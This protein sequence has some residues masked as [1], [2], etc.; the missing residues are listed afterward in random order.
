MLGAWQAMSGQPSPSSH[1]GLTSM[2]RKQPKLGPPRPPFLA[3]PSSHPLTPML[4][5]F[6][7]QAL[8]IDRSVDRQSLL[9]CSHVHL[10]QG[11]WVEDVSI[12][13]RVGVGYAGQWANA[14]LRFCKAKNE[15]VSKP[16]PWTEGRKK[17]R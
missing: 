15:Y 3:Y 16:W 5:R 1:H 11:S 4:A 14:P 9:D 7:K 10:E 12:G 8:G 6:V 2:K 17:G 13:P